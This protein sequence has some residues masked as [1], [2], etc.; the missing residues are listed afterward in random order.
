MAPTPFTRLQIFIKLNTASIFRNWLITYKWLKYNFFP[1]NNSNIKYIKKLILKFPLAI[2][3]NKRNTIY[4]PT[5]S[6]WKKKKK[7]RYIYTISRHWAMSHM[8][9]W[10]RRWETNEVR[11]VTAPAYCLEFPGLSHSSEWENGAEAWQTLWVEKRKQR[12]L[13]TLWLEFTGKGRATKKDNPRDL[14]RI[15]LEY[16]VHAHDIINYLR[17]ERKT[18]W[19]ERK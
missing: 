10:S 11:P 15:L 16:S 18:T 1:K 14:Q 2:K 12:V 3:W 4:L 7:A 9:E 17:A 8:G 19:T 13:E 6:N 5:W